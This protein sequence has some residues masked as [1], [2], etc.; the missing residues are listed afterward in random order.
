MPEPS[1]IK[2]ATDVKDQEK[3]QDSLGRDGQVD[4]EETSL[5]TPVPIQQDGYFVGHDTVSV[6]SHDAP[7]TTNHGTGRQEGPQRSKN[8]TGSLK[9]LS[10]RSWTSNDSIR[11]AVSTKASY[12]QMRGR[13]HSKSSS[14]SL[15]RRSPNDQHPVYPDQS[16]AQL[17]V[18][19]RPG[20]PLRT[21]SSH[22]AQNGLYNDLTQQ[23]SR[24]PRQQGVK[25]LDNTPLSSPGLYTQQ[26]PASVPPSDSDDSLHYLQTPKETHKVDIEHDAYTGN[27][28]IN[29]YEIV[30]ELGRGEHGKVKLGRNLETGA[31]VAIKIVPRYSRQ[32]R[33][34]R[35]GA[36]ED[37][38]KKEVAILKKARH[39]HVVSLLEVIDDPNKNKVYLVLEFVDKGEIKWRKTGVLEIIRIILG[40]FEQEKKGDGWNIEP[41]QKEKW[42]VDNARRRHEHLERQ[43]IL[44]R[45][46]QPW[47]LEHGDTDEDSHSDISRSV[48]RADLPS[49]QSSN[50]DHPTDELAGSMYGSYTSDFHPRDRKFSM[51][52]S[53]VSHWSSEFEFEEHDERAYVPALTLE[54]ARRAFRDT[55]LGLEFLHY[56]GIIHRDIKPANL[57][58]TKD[59]A[60]KISDFGVSYLGRPIQEND[61]EQKLTEKDVSAIDDEKELARSVGTPAFWAPELCYEDTAMFEGGKTPKITGALDLWALGITLYCM[62]YARLPFNQSDTVGLHEA[63]CSEEVFV[64][65][66]RLVPVDTTTEKPTAFPSTKEINSNKRTDYELKFEEVP[67]HVR[68]LIKKL[69][70]KDPA[71][72]MTI[73][74]AKKQPWVLEGVSDPTAFKNPTIAE[75]KINRILQPD[76]KEVSHA[77]V[78]RNIIERAIGGAASAVG[79]LTGSLLGRSTTRKRTTSN[80]TSSSESAAS[81]PGSNASTV[82]KSKESRRQSLKPDDLTEA[83]KLSRGNSD[84]PLAQS[85]SASPESAEHSSYFD[86]E[87]RPRGPDRAISVMSTAESIRTIKAPQPTS[88]PMIPDFYSD[89]SEKIN[90]LGETLVEGSRDTWERLTS[91]TRWGTD[92]SAS[93][94]RNSSASDV[95][96]A[97]SLAITTASA[98]GS[99]VSPEQLL[100]PSEQPTSSPSDVR[101]PLSP[102]EHQP[103]ERARS[104]LS[105]RPHTAEHRSSIERPQPERRHSAFQ[106]PASTEEAYEHAREINQRRL[107]QETQAKAEADAEAETQRSGSTSDE[108]PPSP[109]DIAYLEKFQA[110]PSQSTLASSGAPSS[111]SQNF[112]NQSFGVVSNA[113]SPPEGWV[114]SE[115]KEGDPEYMRT[116][117]TVKEVRPAK[118]IEDMVE[119]DGDDEDSE[120]EGMMMT[121]AKK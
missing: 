93:S 58:L 80:A 29:N 78:R 73:Q 48:S 69:L 120:D 117:D 26:R 55:L 31:Q 27:K 67:D 10:D 97:P 34:G 103:F 23:L 62:I 14:V 56:I 47:S 82:G 72:R 9:S 101:A 45:G 98:T 84:H 68:D 76:E 74:E 7:G 105:E 20:P 36:P 107:V 49:R 30:S 19:Y 92:R 79:R 121:A 102:L 88:R 109:D 116:A 22:P 3:M 24:S 16:F 37:K 108:C 112:S 86:E 18:Q 99:L 89:F 104:P 113:S 43:R 38:T 115:P 5:K 57:L 85:Q 8:S 32:R 12:G 96:T 4:E 15:P 71:H 6:E 46:V 13:T 21:R 91:R 106:P 114:T 90:T 11:R 63:I 100:S 33:L 17:H 119:D 42:E 65:K 111:V 59:G 50:D 94:S 1:S 66:L 110:A 61:P 2:W 70:V 28:L 54:E 41:T 60:V 52:L 39:P 51:A 81:P 35:L 40:R 53:A 95:R 77:V 25:T 118:A 87:R 44:N 64:P 83:L 75:E